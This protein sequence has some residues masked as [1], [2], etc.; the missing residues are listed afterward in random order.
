M[1]GII[2]PDAVMAAVGFVRAA[3]VSRRMHGTWRSSRAGFAAH[4]RTQEIAPRSDVTA[5]FGFVCV[6]HGC[7]AS[8]RAATS[9]DGRISGAQREVHARSPGLDCR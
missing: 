4:F 7:D 1:F 6:M 9:N 3:V 8:N 2:L 5:A